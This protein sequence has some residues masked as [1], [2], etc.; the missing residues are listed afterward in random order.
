MRT[1][2]VH[3][4]YEADAQTGAVSPPIYQTATFAF[5][6]AEQGAA[7]FAHED[8]GYIYTRYGNLT[9]RV[10][11]E[12]MAALEGAEAALAT[13]SGMAAIATVLLGL[14]RYGDHVVATDA[15][16]TATR[17]LLTQTLPGLGV[18]CTVVDGASPDAV[19][20]AIRPNTR[21]I[22]TETPGNPTLKLVEL[23]PVARIG[24]EHG[25]TTITDSTFATPV[26]LRPIEHGIDLVVH[27]A[28]KYLGGH[29]DIIG[30]IICGSREMID[31]LWSTH[32]QVGGS[33][34][35]LN[36]FLLARGLQTLPLRMAAHNDNARRIAEFL[37]GHSAVQ[38]VIY[39]GLPSHPQHD[40]ARREMDGFGGMVCFELVGGIE[41]GRR[42]MN[43]VK[44]CTLAVSL[45]DVKTLISH[46]ASM[47]HSLLSAQERAEA[48]I[49]E[50]LV[51]LSVGI[52][53]PD[54]LIADLDQA[55][56][57]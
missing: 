23:E 42:L 41:A 57:S 21:A 32:I 39:P 15:L 34:S 45:G 8:A 40:L 27:S 56:T 37:A 16:Y 29:G 28:T 46:P 36:A 13:A 26:N 5:E 18:T 47:T 55:L 2:A 17:V 11:E 51:R 1:R 12:R 30:G 14:L 4:G 19:A 54:D 3:A 44:L 22:Y 25:I 35:P 20:K 52:E 6:S 33:M 24:R 7:R 10:V 38:R 31:R 9:T 49:S 43:S 53:D 48:G 50:G